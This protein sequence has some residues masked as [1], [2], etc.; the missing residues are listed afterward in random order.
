MADIVVRVTP[1][2]DQQRRSL[3]PDH[4]LASDETMAHL[5][6]KLEFS[7]LSPE[8]L[9]LEP[10]ALS[11]DKIKEYHQRL[12]PGQDKPGL[13]IATPASPV[14]QSHKSL[15]A[16]LT[17]LKTEIAEDRALSEKDRARDEEY[18]ARFELRRAEDRARFELRRAEDRA[19]FELRRV[20]DH[21][22]FENARVEDIARSEQGSACFER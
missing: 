8:R 21:A 10:P 13:L 7:S 9:R 19:R 4:Y 16:S 14:I 12:Y 18:R 11:T 1:P 22:R 2:R 5:K 20:E 6:R 3:P 15:E 17:D